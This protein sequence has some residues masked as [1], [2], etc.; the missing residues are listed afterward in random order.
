MNL[1][2]CRLAEQAA[3]QAAD[4]WAEF[5]DTVTDY[6]D[7]FGAVATVAGELPLVLGVSQSPSIVWLL[8]LPQK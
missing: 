4:Y 5:A 7:R 2:P 1:L 6:W 8:R 3:S